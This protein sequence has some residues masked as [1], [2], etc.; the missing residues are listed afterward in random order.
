MNRS[1]KLCLF[2]LALSATLAV[3]QANTPFQHVIIV[4]QENRTPDNLFGSDVFAKTRQLPGAD[5]VSGGPCEN[6]PPKPPYAIALQPIN[7][8]NACDPN[9][10]HETSWVPTYDGGAMD[11]ACTI[12]ASGCTMTYS[13]ELD[14][15]NYSYVQSSDVVPYFQ[16]ASQYGY[17][18]YMFQTSQGPSFLAHQFLFSGT[19][20]PDQIGDTYD[21]CGTGGLCYHEWFA[22]ENAPKKNMN[23]GCPGQTTSTVILEVK[24]DDTIDE[25]PGYPGYNNAYAGYPC[26]NHPTLATVLDD[27]PSGVSP[28][29]W[30]FY[31]QGGA[32]GLWT[33]P[34]AISAICVPL[35]KQ[36]NCNGTEWNAKVASFFPKQ[37]NYLNSYS[38]ILTDLGVNTPNQAG[39]CALPGVSWVIPDGNWSD[40]A[41]EDPDGAGPSWV[42]AIV[43]AVGGVY[44]D[45]SGQ[46]HST[47]C[48]YW[49]NTVVLITWDDWGGWYDHVEPWNSNGPDCCGYPGDSFYSQQYVYGF[50]VPLLVVSAYTGTYS[51][52]NWSGYISGALPPNGPG[53]QQPY[54]HDFGSILNFVEY[55]FGQ[56]G[57]PITSAEGIYPAYPYADYYAPDGYFE[58]KGTNPY[59]LADFF[60]NNF[61]NPLRPFT[62]I[63]HG[64]NYPGQCFIEPTVSSCFG[65][66]FTPLDPDADN[67][68]A[69]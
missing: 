60:P 32:D 13:P 59:S 67:V 56:G 39:Q 23:Y 49:D 19:S 63:T 66:G 25:Y 24:P 12:S 31:S 58:T 7:L 29:T 11:G 65:P 2:S 1:A 48:S 15:Q 17:G 46:Q 27:P 68:D 21:D 62:P 57:K 33:A 69:D 53:E 6:V 18:N 50:R 64:V 36:G 41:G 16:I 35:D 42:A 4:V 43:N 8:G 51:K 3:A 61:Q 54:V 52:L 20:A 30:K 9:H 22:A 38:P 28:I 14:F 55:A 45:I 34:N 26:Y 47:G 5:L 10:S 37:G 40:H 44:Y